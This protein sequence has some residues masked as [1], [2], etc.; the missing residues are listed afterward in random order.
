MSYQ[1]GMAALNLEMPSRVPRTE[2]SAQSHWELISAV[3][4]LSVT[5][6]SSDEEKAKAAKAFT[7]PDCWNY[8]FNW[9]VLIGRDDLGEYQS[10]MGHAV[11]ASEG[12]DYNTAIHNAFNTPE[13]A[14]AFQPM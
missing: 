13:E 5:Q 4:G 11:Y 12:S 8:D 9:S 7:G 1:D 14:L 6:A 10:T 3:T 2:Y